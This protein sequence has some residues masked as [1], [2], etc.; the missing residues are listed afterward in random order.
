MT[1]MPLRLVSIM[2][3]VLTITACS[4]P[5]VEV[6][7]EDRLTTIEVPV[8]CKLKLPRCE[9]SHA[10]Y[11]EKVD[12]LSNCLVLRTKAAKVCMELEDE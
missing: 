11:T 8:K 10:T 5:S 6:R 9:I 2:L 3:L 1:A 4:K 7:Y 12:S